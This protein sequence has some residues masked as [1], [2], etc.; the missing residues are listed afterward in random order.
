MKIDTIID[1]YSDFKLSG[2][3]GAVRVGPDGAWITDN[4]Y[5]GQMY[6]RTVKVRRADGTIALETEWVTN[7]DMEQE[8]RGE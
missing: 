4:D 1:S 3:W 7:E 5:D 6:A 2:S 8:L